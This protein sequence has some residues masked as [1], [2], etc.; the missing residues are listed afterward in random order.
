MIIQKTK[1]IVAL[2]DHYTLKGFNQDL[3]PFHQSLNIL[4]LNN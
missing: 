4:I 3:V 1:G 2:S